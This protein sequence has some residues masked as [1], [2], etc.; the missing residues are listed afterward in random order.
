MK[1]KDYYT[2]LGVSRTATD[3]EI[4][5]AYRKLARK[6]HP[7][8]SKEPEAEERFKSVQEAYEVLKDPQ[9]RATYDQFGSNWKGGQDFTPPPEAGFENIFTEGFGGAEG[10]SDFFDMFF[11]GQTS[12][13]RQPGF[14]RRGKKKKPEVQNVDLQISLE[15]AYNGVAKILQ[16]KE[17]REYSTDQAQ[18]KT[19]KINIPPGTVNG[20][21]LRLSGGKNLGATDILV[22]VIVLQHRIFSVQDHDIYLNLP[23]APWEAALGAKIVVPTLGGSVELKV[24]AGSQTG[25]KLRLKGRGLPKSDTKGDQYVV[26]QIVNPP[27]LNDNQRA[28]YEALSKESTFDPREALQATKS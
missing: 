10:F 3:A 9:K 22:T 12:G 4:K 25:N 7:D 27:N 24:V 13:R 2:T 28:L 21:K 8:V 6:Y 19:L 18:Y 23:I 26:L 14:N 11:G 5:Q 17:S 1:Y 20:Q 15:E 16:F